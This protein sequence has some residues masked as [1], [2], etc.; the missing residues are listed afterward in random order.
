[1][2]EERMRFYH[3]TSLPALEEIAESKELKP[4]VWFTLAPNFNQTRTGLPD[5]KMEVAVVID[6]SMGIPLTQDP[7]NKEWF[8][9]DNTISFGEGTI[10]IALPWQQEERLKK[11][12]ITIA[13][14]IEESKS[15][16]RFRKALEQLLEEWHSKGTPIKE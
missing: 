9:T 12:Y 6:D 8:Y 15:N 13:D 1:M 4:A 11:G 16:R 2:R 14:L 7:N 5:D 3:Y 10:Y